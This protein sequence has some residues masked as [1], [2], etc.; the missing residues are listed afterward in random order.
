MPSADVL[1]EHREF[2][3]R[4]ARGILHDADAADDVAQDAIVAALGE[5]PRNLRGWLGKVA[6]HLALSRRRAEARRDL[7]ERAAA[8]PEALPSAAEGVARL[9]IQRKV[10][11]AV[12]ALDEPYR[13]VVVHRFFFDLAPGEIAKRLQ[14][15]V[16]TV[17]TRLRRALEQL[18]ARLDASHGRQAWSVALLALAVP[19]KTPLGGIVAMSVKSKLALTAVLALACVALG[20]SVLSHRDAVSPRAPLKEEAK[21]PV[22]PEAITPPPVSSPVPPPVDFAAIDR[23]RDV[24]GVVVDAEGK[25]VVGADVRVIRY[26]AMGVAVGLAQ[27]ETREGPGTRTASDGSFALRVERGEEV[28]LRIDAKGFVPLQRR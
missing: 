5:R 13:S 23:D 20:V 14:V 18:R 27:V 6:R 25:P 22:G 28:D 16:E 3:R 12:L 7:R 8:R 26:P 11:D 10:V 4:L 2:L 17:R 19:R 15:P 24:H 1:L 21:Q 9:E